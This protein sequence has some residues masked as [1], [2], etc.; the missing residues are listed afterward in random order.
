MTTTYRVQSNHHQ[1]AGELRDALLD[2]SY[3][4]G[5][6]EDLDCG[7]DVEVDGPEA[8]DALRAR[9]ELAAREL[10]VPA[11]VRSPDGLLTYAGMPRRTRV[12]RSG[13]PARRSATGVRGPQ[14]LP[15]G[16]GWA[17]GPQHS[18]AATWLNV[19]APL[20]AARAAAADLV[21]CPVAELDCAKSVIILKEEA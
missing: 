15:D 11:W 16:W 18:D 21:G 7:F 19:F 20:G 9:V 3:E 2:A 8:L 13:A 12:Q 10:Q 5:E 1:F 14:G 6:V 17:A 4:P